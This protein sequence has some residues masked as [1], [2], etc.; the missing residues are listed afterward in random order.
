MASARRL[1]YPCGSNFCKATYNSAFCTL[2]CLTNYS[3]TLF[4]CQT[5]LQCFL[6]KKV[7]HNLFSIM[8]K[9]VENP[10]DCAENL[11]ILAKIRHFSCFYAKKLWKTFGLRFSFII[12]FYKTID[13]LQKIRYNG[14]RKRI[15]RISKP[16]KGGFLRERE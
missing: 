3:T 10:V 2:L 12:I 8:C 7:F 16:Q 14:T 13:F 4:V 6:C 15:K 9:T 1:F 11:H 5:N